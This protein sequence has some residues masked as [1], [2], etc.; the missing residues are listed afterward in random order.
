MPHGYLLFLYKIVPKIPF[1]FLEEYLLQ[2]EH[3]FPKMFEIVFCFFVYNLMLQEIIS[4]LRLALSSKRLS[5]SI[6]SEK[7]TLLYVNIPIL[8]RL[9]LLSILFA[10]VVLKASLL[11]RSYILTCLHKWKQ[12][13]PLPIHS[14][15]SSHGQL[16][17]V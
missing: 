3:F 14:L 15:A 10:E 12:Q 5:F 6:V 8:F 7:V 9:T 2:L 11:E 13:Y 4:L 17:L 16:Q 1:L